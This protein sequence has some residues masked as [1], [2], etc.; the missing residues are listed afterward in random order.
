MHG[1][2]KRQ[3]PMDTEGGVISAPFARNLLIVLKAAEALQDTMP[4]SKMHPSVLYVYLQQYGCPQ[5][6]PACWPRRKAAP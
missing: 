2:N 5:L 4:R 6:R 3:V 1:T